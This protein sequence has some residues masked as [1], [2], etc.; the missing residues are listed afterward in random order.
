MHAKRRPAADKERVDGVVG[1][2]VKP[3]L[4]EECARADGWGGGW[5]GEAIV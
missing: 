3:R 5:T 4:F 2:D 1:G